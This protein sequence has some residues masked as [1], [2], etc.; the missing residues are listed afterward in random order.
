[1]SHLTEDSRSALAPR[2]RTN[3]Q[4]TAE[5]NQSYWSTASA[6]ASKMLLSAAAAAAQQQWDKVE[7]EWEVMSGNKDCRYCL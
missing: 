5:C 1:M 3:Y 7:G 4:V 6:H 2:G